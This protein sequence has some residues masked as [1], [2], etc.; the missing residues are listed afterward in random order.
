MAPPDRARHLVAIHVGHADVQQHERGANSSKIVSAADPEWPLALR[1]R[2]LEEL[3][4]AVRGIFVVIHDQDPLA[5][6]AAA[7]GCGSGATRARP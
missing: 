1:S 3:A 5:A 7:R 6:E 2:V 4:K